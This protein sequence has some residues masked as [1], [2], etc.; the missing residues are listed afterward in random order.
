MS[1]ETFIID[2]RV[3]PDVQTFLI[4]TEMLHFS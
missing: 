1:T 2:T 3:A 4:Y